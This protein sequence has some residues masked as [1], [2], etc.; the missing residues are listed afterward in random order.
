MRNTPASAGRTGVL[1]GLREKVAEHPRVGG[2]DPLGPGC[3]SLMRGTPPRRRE[4]RHLL[5]RPLHPLRNTPASAGRTRHPHGPGP[6]RS[7]HPRVGGKDAGCHQLNDWSDGT[8]PR[9]RE[10]LDPGLTK[11][12]LPRNTPASAGRTRSRGSGP[13]RGAEHPRVGGKDVSGVSCFLVFFG[14][15]PRRREGQAAVRRAGL[16]RRNTPA[17]AGRTRGRPTADPWPPE[18]PR[19]GG[20]DMTEQPITGGFDGTPPRRREGPRRSPPSRRGT[21]NTPAS[22]GRTLSDLRTREGFALP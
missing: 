4:G 14:T 2:K 15:P 3:T 7:E 9:R 16:D 18:H 17:S 8:P 21:R 6:A 20:K 12:N 22:A 10:G 13:G 1:A 5:R 19:V 11:I